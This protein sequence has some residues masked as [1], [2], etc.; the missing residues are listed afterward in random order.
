MPGLK[1]SE[2]LLETA[3]I[4]RRH[5]VV[6]GASDSRF[7]R[8]WA[9]D[10]V[11]GERVVVTSVD[12]IDID[13]Q[14]LLDVGLND[15]NRSYV[16]FVAL[17]AHSESANLRC[18][19]DRD[20]GH[21]VAAHQYSTLLWTDFPALESYALEESTLDRANLLSFK[22]KLPEA[23]VLLP[24]LAFALSELFA[25]RKQHEHMAKP[26]YQAGFK[27]RDSQLAS[28][29]V[30]ATVNESIRANV[31]SYSR[32]PNDADPRTYAYGHDIV[33]LLLA[34]YGNALKNQAGL[35]SQ[36]AVEGALRS[37]TQIVGAYK[38]E[39]MF[40]ELAAWVAA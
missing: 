3:L 1:V 5:I 24:D 27:T 2:L 16:I 39:P 38:Y 12:A 6:E 14:G 32:P 13:L 31:A 22:E 8:A 11:G 4:S 26:R 34:V 35:N 33:A 15:G 36:E 19:A 37:A 23:S 25:V 17:M 9:K 7:F 20:C 10:T 21:N 18:I 30:A 40:S 28:F 29:D